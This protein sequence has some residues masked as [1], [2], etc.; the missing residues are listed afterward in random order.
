MTPSITP[1]AII[2][3]LMLCVAAPIVGWQFVQLIRGK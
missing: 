1:G 3:F 2:F